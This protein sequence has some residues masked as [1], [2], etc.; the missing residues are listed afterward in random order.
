MVA[1]RAM[2]LRPMPL[3]LSA[4]GLQ[5]VLT[6]PTTLIAGLLPLS[7]PLP[8]HSR[9]PSPAALLLRPAACNF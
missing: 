8:R 9:V 7:Q 1:C 2:V 3:A 6:Q 5:G 4:C